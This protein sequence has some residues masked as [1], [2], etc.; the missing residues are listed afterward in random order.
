MKLSQS[1]GPFCSVLFSSGHQDTT[2]WFVIL[3]SL[4]REIM[5]SL[6]GNLWVIPFLGVTVRFSCL[7]WS[8]PVFADALLV[9]CSGSLCDLC[10]GLGLWALSLGVQVILC[11][12][13]WLHFPLR[14]P[15]FK[16]FSFF[17]VLFFCLRYFPWKS[18]SCCILWSL[19]EIHLQ[20][21]NWFVSLLII[22][23]LLTL[24]CTVFSW[25]GQGF[26][27]WELFHSKHYALAPPLE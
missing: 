19:C 25:G 26:W 8:R 12:G 23:L 15:T 18:V 4:K 24:Y 6:Q 17:K 21:C 16:V 7:T 14:V 22:Q 9:F 3:Q 2:K 11:W 13:F 20:L 27:N 1:I 5:S 10:S